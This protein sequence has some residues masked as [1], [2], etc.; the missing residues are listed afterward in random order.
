[1]SIEYKAKT[2]FLNKLNH[3]LVKTIVI[4]HHRLKLAHD[5]YFNSMVK[6]IDKGID[7]FWIKRSF[8][9]LKLN[10]NISLKYCLLEYK[11]CFEEYKKKYDNPIYE[12]GTHCKNC[13]FRSDKRGYT[14]RFMFNLYTTLKK[15]EIYS[16]NVSNK[17][18]LIHEYI[19]IE[20]LT[21]KIKEHFLKKY[22]YVDFVHEKNQIIFRCLFLEPYVIGKILET[23]L[24][25][26]IVFLIEKYRC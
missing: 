22:I 14:N 9:K 26:D 20:L 17:K 6:F 1:M 25:S 15:Y 18:I 11:E 2:F 3:K 24:P 10:M 4:D 8:K 16:C 12:F 13:H 19:G 5:N 7:D 23:K 21:I